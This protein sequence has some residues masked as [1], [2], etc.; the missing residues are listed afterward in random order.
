MAS[1]DKQILE[2]PGGLRIEEDLSI[3]KHPPKDYRDKRAA[4]AREGHNNEAAAKAAAAIDAGA[5]NDPAFGKKSGARNALL[6]HNWEGDKDD[7]A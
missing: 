6:F 5:A 3:M 4:N 7:D 1:E 2:G